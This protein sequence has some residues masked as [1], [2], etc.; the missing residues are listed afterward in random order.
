MTEN[1]LEINN[2]DVFYGPFQAIRNV[3]LKV[4]KGKTIGLFGPNGHG[5][6]TILKAISGIQKPSHGTI[7]FEGEE[8]TDLPP[9]EIVK[10]GLIQVPQGAHLF[11]YMSVKEN[12]LLGAYSKIYWLNREEK[13]EKVYELFPTLKKRENQQARTLSGGERQM[14]SLGRGLMAGDKLLMLDEP[15]M[16][17][18]PIAAEELLF[19]LKEIKDLGISIVLVEQNLTYVTEL[20]EYLYL[21]ES[22][23]IKL[24]G[25]QEEMLNKEEIIEAY[26]GRK[27]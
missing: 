8:I 1:I 24:E 6:T 21:V 15:S 27:L 14:V 20:C 11:G 3:S 26:L 2:I 10:R 22:A 4:E 13:L 25:I 17:L 16:G 7:I 19:K 12:L 23:E 5:K 9:E 18:S